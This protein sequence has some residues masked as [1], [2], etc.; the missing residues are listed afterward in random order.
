MPAERDGRFEVRL[1]LGGHSFFVGPLIV[2]VAA[3]VAVTPLLFRGPSCGHDFDFHLV[4]WLD[5]L[6]SWRH[7]IFY[8]QWTPSANYG[9]G[10]PRF[11][12]YPPLTWMLGA[13]LGAILPWTLAPI[14]LTFLL[15]AGTGLS[16]RALAREALTD[17]AATLAGCAALFSGYALYTAYERTAYGELAGGFWIPLLLLFALRA[18]SKTSRILE[19]STLP[20][21]LVL[22][23]CWLSNIPLGVMACY[24]LAAL[25]VLAAILDRSIAPVDCLVKSGAID[26]SITSVST[27]PRNANHH[28]QVFTLRR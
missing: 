1:R 27:F 9:A 23:G 19:G 12:F 13:A 14:A 8:P 3:A 5:C 18:P 7:G 21:A 15:L 10:E 20:L 16:T 4:S 24:L 11:V 25:A 22:A 2:L 6:N 17:G 26:E 28:F